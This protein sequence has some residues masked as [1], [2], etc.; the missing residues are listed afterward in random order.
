MS[1]KPLVTVFDGA[2]GEI[3]ERE[4]TAQEIAEAKS[5]QDD[6]Q[7]AKNETEAKQASRLSALEKL[8]ALGLTEAEIAAL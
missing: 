2:T 7:A 5:A 8:K 1:N 4:A 3:V 6:I